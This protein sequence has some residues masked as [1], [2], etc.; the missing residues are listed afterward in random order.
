MQILSELIP[1]RSFFQ[2]SLPEISGLACRLLVLAS[3]LLFLASLAFGQITNVTD[4]QSTPIP[5]AGHDYIHMLTETV[6][7]AN[8]SVSL[9]IQVPVPMGRRLTLPFSFAYDSNGVRHLEGDGNGGSLWISND[10]MISQGGWA[11]SV[12]QL[13]AAWLTQTVNGATCDYSTDFVFQDPSGGRHAL[14]ISDTGSDCGPGFSVSPVLSGGDDFLRAS[15]PYQNAVL[16][17]TSVVDADGTVF[18][19]SNFLGWGYNPFNEAIPDYVEDRN[20]N[21]IVITNY[22]TPKGANR[23]SFAWT[24]T[25]GRLALS[26]SGFGATGN[27]ITVSGLSNPYTVSW[28]AAP[29]SYPVNS[30]FLDPPVDCT[31]PPGVSGSQSVISAIELPNGSSYRFSY[32]PTYGLV[33]KIVY[34][35]GG[36]VRYTWG[37]NPLAEAA[38]YV[39]A[40]PYDNC[41]SP[42]YCEY[43]Y[44]SPVVTH[45]YVSFDGVTEVLEQDFGYSVTWSPGSMY[46]TSKQTTVTTRDLVRNTTT[47]TTYTYT[48]FSLPT[49]PND[50]NWGAIQVPLEESVVYQDGS[51]HRLRSV[52]KSWYDQYELKSQQATLDSGQTSETDYSYG[53]GAQVTEKDEYA[54]GSGSRGALLRKTLIN[55][56]S[57]PATPIYPSAPSIFDRPA[58]VITYDG[59]GNR[60]AETD[61]GYDQTA[62]NSVS[63]LTGHDDTNYSASYNNRGN[64][65]TKTEWLNTGGSSPVTTYTHDDTGQTVTMTDSRSNPT[66]YAYS[67]SDAYL[68][69]ITYPST[70]GVN[71]VENFAYDPNSGQLTSSKDQNGNPTTYAYSDPLGRLTSIS[72]PD[73]GS[74]QYS[75][76]D[77]VP[78]ITT[79]KSIS[80]GT[81]FSSTTVLDGMGHTIQTQV[82][83]DPGGTVY[84]DT[85][86]DGEGRVWRKSNPHRA[87]GSSTDGITTYSYDAL[88]RTTLIVPPDG[89]TSANNTTTAYIGNATTVTDE[90]GRQ[91][92]YVHDA[93]GRLTEVDE[94]AATTVSPVAVAPYYQGGSGG[95][96]GSG[97]GPLEQAVTQSQDWL[98]SQQQP[99]AAAWEGNALLT[100]GS[101]TNTQFQES[102]IYSA[103]D[104]STLAQ[105]P[106]ENIVIDPPA[107][108][109]PDS[110]TGPDGFP[111]NYSPQLLPQG[112]IF[113]NVYPNPTGSSQTLNGHCF[114]LLKPTSSYIVYIFSKTDQFYYMGSAT[115]VSTGPGTATWSYTGYIGAGA[116]IAVL[117][118]ASQPTPPAYASTIPAGWVVHSNSGVGKKLSNY[119]ARLFVDTDSEYQYEDNVP[120]IVQDSHHLRVGS[121]VVPVLNT[122]KATMQIVYNDPVSGPTVVYDSLETLAGLQGLPLSYDIPTND[123]LYV[124]PPKYLGQAALQNRSFIY[125]DALAILA[126]SAAGEY[127]RASDIIQQ[128]NYRIDNPGYMASAIL[129]NAEDGS[130]SNWGAAGG[131]V[132][133]I[134]DPTYPPYGG[135]VLDFHASSSG[136]TFTY[137]GSGLPNSI[138]SM[139]SFQWNA[140]STPGHDFIFD[141]GVATAAG[142]VTDVQVT[143]DTPTLPSYNSSTKIITVPIG[144]GSGSYGTT[145]ENLQSLVSSLTGDSL[146]SIA[147]FKVTLNYAG[148]MKFNGLSVGNLQPAGSLSFSYD[149]Y[150]GNVDQAY[151]RTGAMAWVVYAYCMYMQESGDYTPALYVQKM[152]NFIETLKSPASDLTNSLYYLGWGRYQ[153]PGYEYIP[154]LQSSVSTEHQG[155]L[156][157]AWKVAAGI[158]PTAASALEQQ[159][160]ITSDQANSLNAT[161]STV[162][163]EADTIWSKASAILY[164]APSSPAWAASQAYAVGAQV[165]DSNGNFEK[166]VV[167]GTSGA[168]SPG[169]PTATGTMVADGSV[170]WELTSLAGNAG[171]FA[172]GVSGINI[173]TS[174][175]LDASGTW[176]ALLA[177]AAGDDT[178][179]AEALKFVYQNF[180]ITNQTIQLS[181]VSNSYNETYQQT[182]AFSG[183]KPYN[184]SSNGYSGSPASVWQEGTWGM[185]DALVHVNSVPAVQSYFNSVITCSPSPCTGSQGVD[186]LL[187]TLV[188][189]QL[190]VWDTTANSTTGQHS[191]LGYSLASRGLPYEFEVWPMLSATSWFWITT[192]NP[193]MLFDPPARPS[194]KHA[195]LIHRDKRQRLMDRIEHR[196]RAGRQMAN[197]R[198][199][200]VS[201]RR[202]RWRLFPVG[203]RKSRKTGR[204]HRGAGKLGPG[205]PPTYYTYD[206][207]GNLIEVQQQGGSTDSSQWRTR[208]FV[209]DSLSRL[210]SASN[211][212]SGTTTYNYDANGNLL[213]KTG[214]RRITTTYS[215]DALNRLTGKTYSDSEPAVT[216]GYDGVA[217]AV[218]CPPASTPANPIGNH[219]SM[220][221]AA[222]DETWGYDQMNRVA[223]DQRKSNGVTKSSSYSY[224][225]DGSL[226]TLTYPS[227]RAVTYQVGGA[228]LPLSA[229]DSGSGV[230]YISGVMYAPQGALVTAALASGNISLIQSYSSRLQ[231]STIQA[232][233]AGGTELLDFAYDFGLGT[234]DNGDVKA[235]VNNR[236]TTRT[237]Y[238]AYDALNRIDLANTQTST[239]A[240]A[241]GQA[242]GYD[243]WGNLTSVTVTQG[244]APA[245]SVGVNANN[246]LSGAPYS[247]DAAG[248]ILTDALNTYTWNAEGKMATV[249]SPQGLVTYTYDGDGRR[250]EKSSGKLYWYGADGNVLAEGDASGNITDEY[251]FFGEKRIARVDAQGNVDYYLSDS[252]GSS[253]VVTDSNGN[254]LD[255]CD[256][257]PFGDEQCVASSSGNNYKFI[258]MER[259]TESQ[260]DHT[261]NRQFSSTYAR[262]L[263]PDPLGGHL[264]DPQTLNKYSYVRNNPLNLTDSTGLDIWLQGC[265]VD[266]ETD[267]CHDNYV[268]TWNVEHTHFTRTHL[269]DDQTKTASLGPHGLS[270]NYTVNGKQGTYAGIWDTNKHE[271]NPVDV[272]GKGALSSFIAEINGN[273]GGTC[274]A[275]GRLYNAAGFGTTEQTL[276]SAHDVYTALDAPGSGY[277]RNAGLDP[278]D[279]FHKGVNF[280]GY[281]DTDPDLLFSTHVPVPKEDPRNHWN[282]SIHVDSVYPYDDLV[283]FFTH[284]ASVVR[285]LVPPH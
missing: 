147:A 36:Y 222:G 227:G 5:G 91:M 145:L 103:T 138:S 32:D 24:D 252:L 44:D 112:N 6:N 210:T 237:Q 223:T 273:C 152:I 279:R 216:Y 151:I 142:M 194:G 68:S 250:V 161:A 136:A 225:L 101:G 50:N 251:I 283:D 268:G 28:E 224:Y 3:L 176:S 172:Q 130:T 140:P 263:S 159:G 14:G 110:S 238:F 23:G 74:T 29:A 52:N 165:T 99:G 141:I 162:S 207:L 127:G 65:T 38:Y 123:P 51:G 70:N 154:G 245:L 259:D 93:L 254:I 139:I 260:L 275:S 61:Y 175:A 148:D 16:P 226:K 82:T 280:R 21:K 171:H 189:G 197:L 137:T 282:R 98:N 113:L 102:G 37:T 262:W 39:A 89:S 40:C 284:G 129:E 42:N 271:S 192:T 132:T 274:V 124:P 257:M 7:P 43:R 92:R 45:R 48:P 202:V 200:E 33:S 55:Y 239:G 167:A 177:Y 146:T 79:T 199:G 156:Y 105:T 108:V 217:G 90:T 246:Q 258:G 230:K 115:P 80:S 255:D 143:G 134:N 244:T 25:T 180:Y 267:T 248:N 188:N 212:E 256:F 56:A 116:V 164:T 78:S 9:R 233:S 59:S 15:L 58:S 75:Y 183:F 106:I 26:S 64:A 57:F 18:Y 17:P 117:Y 126:Y 261:L 182:T 173:D 2:S 10:T 242:F 272:A 46:W 54:Y 240:N 71:H 221:D 150:N 277:V 120:I 232:T 204:W 86:Y 153:N 214:A 243:P 77:G 76:D 83:S 13:S 73:G 184:D 179:A 125:D 144:L 234:A 53:P 31:Q 84:T 107:G 213:T 49:P 12:P 72:Y 163:S 111:I 67:N 196:R 63:G 34:P 170:T 178:K 88:G 220:C 190:A 96:S 66:Q 181:N 201:P 174:E 158:L 206:A 198:N 236:D 149:V 278:I 253:R 122:G 8:G 35:T 269:K 281:S 19:F 219:T 276:A 118:P 22:M 247:Y 104:L 187:T 121:S 47:Q 157:F 191:V 11:Y 218:N 205:D 186:T 69:Q 203:G 209:Y 155:D 60:V 41:G 235:I 133:N 100:P 27:T 62:V 231:P 211:P 228:E 114:N 97:A 30:L 1:V 94:P 208:T 81:T 109:T 185:V 131:T 166:C 20:G 241:W 215:Y 270:V 266:N 249:S 160:L 169:W 85:T 168:S 195:P 87:S 95:G 4:D 119:F 285:S 128:L 135:Q 193:T 264:E 265:G 229:T